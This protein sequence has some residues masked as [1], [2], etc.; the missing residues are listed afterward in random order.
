[1]TPYPQYKPSGF[2]WLGDI[3]EGW[4]LRK[5]KFTFSERNVKGCPGEPLLA[6]TQNHGVILKSDYEN[7]T[8]VATKSLKSLKLVEVGDFVISL[9]SFQGGIELAHQRGIISPAYTILKPTHISEDYFKYFAKSPTFIAL[10][11]S[12]V[13]G[14]REGQNIDYAKLRDELLPI[15]PLQEQRAIGNYLDSAT[16][17]IDQAIASEERAIDL[18]QERKQIIIEHAITG[19]AQRTG[20]ERVVRKVKTLFAISRGRVIS[21][22]ELVESGLYPVYS[23]QTENDGCLGYINTYDYEGEMLSWTTDGARAGTVFHRSG[24]FNCTNVCGMLKP[25]TNNNLRYLFYAVGWSAMQNRRA[26]ILGFKVMSNEMA[27][28]PVLVPSPSEQ[29]AIVAHLDAATAKIDRAIE[30][31]RRQIELLRERREIIIDAAVTGKAK[32]S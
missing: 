10:L 30:V 4:E 16:A 12:K 13:T 29:E 3:P 27:N 11:K 24:R 15:P 8:V 7:R 6:A 22:D 19:G 25:T 2:T 21:R 1:M 32:V 26:D 20:T 18:L 14:I 28:Y 31:K 17:K 9:R 23:S 5:M